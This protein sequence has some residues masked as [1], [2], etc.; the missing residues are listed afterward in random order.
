MA[1]KRRQ[2]QSDSSQVSCSREPTVCVRGKE[3]GV[4]VA[5]GIYSGTARECAK[6]R[7]RPPKKLRG[8]SARAPPT[9]GQK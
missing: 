8:R 1:I 6:D 3:R 4:S 5:L 2:G 7:R 9:R